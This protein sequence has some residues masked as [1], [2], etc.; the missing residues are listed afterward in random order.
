MT[1]LLE[2]HNRKNRDT[3]QWQSFVVGTINQLINDKTKQ[4]WEAINGQIKGLGKKIE[5]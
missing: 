3:N 1:A 2:S 4:M 5:V